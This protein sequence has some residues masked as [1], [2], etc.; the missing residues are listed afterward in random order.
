MLMVAYDDALSTIVATANDLS[1]ENNSSMTVDSAQ[2]GS[3]LHI[4]TLS[5]LSSCTTQRT[6]CCSTTLSSIAKVE[7]HLVSHCCTNACSG[8][9]NSSCFCHKAYVTLVDL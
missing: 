4:L 9:P 6:C 5:W 1:I 2:S 3:K 8:I 7:L